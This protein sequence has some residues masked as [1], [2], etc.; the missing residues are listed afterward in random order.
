MTHDSL[1]HLAFRIGKPKIC[2]KI[3]NATQTDETNTEQSG[4]SFNFNLYFQTVVKMLSI[5]YSKFFR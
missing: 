5:L 4:N 3:D 1:N 2:I